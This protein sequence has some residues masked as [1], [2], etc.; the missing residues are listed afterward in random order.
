MEMLLAFATI[1]AHGIGY[2]ADFI[3]ISDAEGFK[4]TLEEVI[5]LF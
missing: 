1:P 4:K 3:K 5:L 2:N